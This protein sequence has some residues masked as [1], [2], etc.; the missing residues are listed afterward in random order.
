[1]IV[2]EK[3]NQTSSGARIIALFGAGLIGSSIYEN[4]I[5]QDDFQIFHL[6]FDWNDAEQR[7]EDVGGIIN[8]L[9]GLV[10]NFARKGSESIS[11]AFIWSAGKAGFTATEQCLNTELATFSTVLNLVQE[12]MA[13]FPAITFSFHHISSAGGLFEGQRSVDNQSSPRPKRFYGILKLK[14]E[15]LLSQLE[16]RLRKAV[17]RPTSVYGFVGNKSRLGLIPTLI[18]NGIQNKVST[19]YGNLSTLRDYVFS[20][21]IANFL[22]KSLFEIPPSPNVSTFLLGS[23][24]P[25]SIYEIRHCIENLICKKIYLEFKITAETENTSD[26]TL[27]SS[28]FPAG[29]KCTDL[30][31]GIRIVKE[32]VMF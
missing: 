24:K 11:L 7:R 23:G 12:M 32:R 9:S 1:M 27:N 30:K 29:W 15:I 21:D 22:S 28:A 5:Q 4:I 2:L 26:I 16:S 17:Y 13:R 25:S 19:I 31:T 10:E 20:N 18:R 8:F 6:P 14:Q 3:I